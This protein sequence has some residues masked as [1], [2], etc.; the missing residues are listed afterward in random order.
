MA[1]RLPEGTVSMLFTDIEGSTR[2]LQ[3]HG[4]KF[5]DMLAQHSRLLRAAAADHRGVEMGRE[6]DAHFF[7][8]TAARDAVRAARDAQAALAD[9]PVQVRIGIHTGEPVIHDDDYVGIDVH[10]AARITSAAH[11]GQVVLSERTR[12]LVGDE[13]ECA[14]LGVHRLKDLLE[15]EKLFQLGSGDFAPLRSLNPTNLPTQPSPLIGRKRELAEV[16]ALVTENR[17]VTL[18]GPG[19]SGKTRLA[20]QVAADLVA[21][22]DDGVFWAPLAAVRDPELVLPAI[23]VAL[24][25]KVSPEEHIDESRLL[26]LADNFEQVLDAA[27]DMTSLMQ[28]CPNLHVAVTSRAPLRIAGEREYAVDA[29]DDADGV[30]LF[31]ERAVIPEPEEAVREICR[32]VDN[33]PLTIELAAARTRIFPPAQLVDR[34]ERRLESLSSGRR[35]V[36]DRHRTL[37]ATID[38]SYELLTRVGREQF[39]RIAIFAGS[40]D[41]EAAAAVAGATD[42]VL[43]TILEG[44]LLNH[45]AGRF[46]MLETIREYGSEQLGR[47]GESDALSERHAAYFLELAERAAQ[48]IEGSGGEAWLARLA[49]NE[50]NLTAALRWLI[51]TGAAEQALRLCVAL[52]QFWESRSQIEEGL[53]WFDLALGLPAARPTPTRAAALRESGFLLTLSNRHTEA[54]VRLRGS[55][56]LSRDAG[57]P[58]E[59][60]MS[61][62]RLG[63]TLY[64]AAPAAAI[65]DL[66]QARATLSEALALSRDSGDRYGEYHTL[67]LL[68]EVARDAGDYDAGA[69]LL[70][71]AIVLAHQVGS[72]IDVGTTK[73]SLADLELD[74]GEVR[75]AED[76]YREVLIDAIELRLERVKAYCVAGLAAVAAVLGED[77]RARLLWQ[78]VEAAESETGVRLLAS[79][80]PRYERLVDR[81]GKRHGEGFAFEDAVALAVR[82]PSSS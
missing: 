30:A 7:V 56:E 28:R 58:R 55:V 60:A 25:A 65:A 44:S 59:L 79:E 39:A 27:P 74:R 33:L 69:E 4:P 14:P 54:L 61:L 51:D 82:P 48:G 32:R 6:G 77:E 66:A 16:R 43:E 45:R 80:R 11:G 23:Q 17:V 73:H 8:F 26:L 50:S 47:A 36:P 19:G 49:L 20:L 81:L 46:W 2:L 35:D 5:P 62:R 34:L 63:A 3:T 57:D 22:F 29:L 71:G 64:T 13:F 10:R 53:R 15:P 21:D 75:R 72:R 76:L 78:G 67:Q 70:E 18:L 24:G 40:F 9:G 37:R 41:L 52:A 68:G 42:D 12:A 31:R 1:P 38:W